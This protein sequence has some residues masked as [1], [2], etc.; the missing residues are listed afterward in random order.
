[1][2]VMRGRKLPCGFPGS[3]P[4]K[5]WNRPMTRKLTSLAAFFVIQAGGF[6]TTPAAAEPLDCTGDYVCTDASVVAT[7]PLDRWTTVRRAS[8]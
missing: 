8:R 5:D 4:T 1:M 6:L 2:L 7:W 3:S